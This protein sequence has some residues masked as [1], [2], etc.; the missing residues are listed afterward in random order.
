MMNNKNQRYYYSDYNKLI[1]LWIVID[2]IKGDALH[3][4]NYIFVC[5][6]FTNDLWPSCALFI[7]LKRRE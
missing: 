2:S 6:Q 7:M 3:I 5:L 1:T 4:F